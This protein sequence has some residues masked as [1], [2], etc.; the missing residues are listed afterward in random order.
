M[1]LVRNE[2]LKQYLSRYPIT[3]LIIGINTLAML[4]TTIMGGLSDPYIV[5][6]LGGLIP[7]NIWGGEYYRLV[8]YAFLHNGM[9]HF[10]MNM[11]F[12]ALIAPPVE[13]MLGKARYILFFV[14]SVLFSGIVIMLLSIG[15]SVGASGY[16]YALLGFFAY[17]IFFRKHLLDPDSRRTLL[18]F[19][20]F[21]W[22]YTFVFPSISISGHLGG[23]ISGILI[24]AVFRDSLK[25][26]GR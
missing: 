10:L 23:F 22:I 1:I 2:N 5:Y 26:V 21:G 6:L 14:F 24:G 18:F 3:C 4:Y 25:H 17:V 9:A 16:G 15:A 11:F 20:L 19:I 12:I 8:T 13:R 7:E